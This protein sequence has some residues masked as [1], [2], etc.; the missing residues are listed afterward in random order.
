MPT[1]SK[2]DQEMNNK[3]IIPSVVWCMLSRRSAKA[4]SSTLWQC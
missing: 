1:N 2:P 3:G 4:L